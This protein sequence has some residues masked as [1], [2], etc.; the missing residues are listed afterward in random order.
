MF[1]IRQWGGLHESPDGDTKL[2]FGEAAVM[3]NFKITRDGNLQRRPGSAT[4]LGLMQAYT[5]QI[6]S[7]AQTVR[8]DFDV[9]ST[10]TMYPAALAGAD[11]FV[12]LSGT[13]ALVSFDNA[14]QYAGYFWRYD[15][16]HI[17]QL[18][19]CTKNEPA[20][21]Y[22]WSMKRVTAVSSSANQRVAGVWSGSIGGM[23]RLVSA[24]DGKLW[25]LWDAENGVFA[26]TEIGDIT[27]T[28]SVFFFGFSGKLY[29]LNGTQ[30]KVWDGTTYADVGGYRPLVSITVPPSGGGETLEQVNK[31]SGTRRCRFSPDGK[32]GTFQLPEKDL[33]SIDYVKKT[34]DGSE[35]VS[36]TDFSVD[37]VNGKV[38]FLTTATETFSGDGS[39]KTFV[40][41]NYGISS[42]SVTVGGAAKT[43][44]TD[45]T[46]SFATHCVEFNTAPVSGTDN[47]VIAENTCP[48]EG[49][50]TVEVGWTVSDN[51]RETVA[52][53]KYAELFNGTQDSRVFLYGDGSNKIFYSGLDY[54][55]NPRADYF[56][57]DNEIALGESNTP[58]TG[59]IRHYS[60][61]LAFKSNSTYSIQ[62]GTVTTAE[63]TMIAAYY[64]TPINRTIGNEAVGQVQLVLNSPRTLFG[65]DL[66]EWKNNS[67]YSSNLS[68]DER[69]AKRISDRIYATLSSFDNAHCVCWDDNENQEY[70]ICCSGCALVHN[71]A[72]DAWYYY[73]GFPVSCMAGFRGETYF[74]TTDGR[75][76]RL[77]YDY[78]TDDG[79]AIQTYWESGSLDFWQ[80]WKRKY[81]QEI[82]VGIK[83]E[84]NAEVSVTVQ[85]DRKSDYN[86]KIV[87]KNLMTF[88]HMNF[89]RF[90]FYTSRK[91]TMTRL[92]LKAKKFTYY[93]LI[94]SNGAG[95]T[96]AT[97]TSVDVKVRY[98]GEV[99]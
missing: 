45:Y 69:Q 82:F 60:R 72:A 63:N 62:Y 65:D 30:Y 20:G 44:G 58:V 49:T 57:D 3:R 50:D 95:D 23:E 48:Q 32:S 37:L 27:T 75:I 70:Y 81:S 93:K 41:S 52:A 4:V 36:G 11:G 97:I 91:P 54:D 86:V 77:S 31:L 28:G 33:A 88:A 39:K 42:M 16:F 64:C 38:T 78:R 7:T 17:W 15:A 59:L 68:V 53:M 80:D 79:E 98:S 21:E 99:K 10:L 74:C 46:Y 6:S 96:T 94:L 90:S 5:T 56:P 66:Y 19:S 1:K 83:P 40:L 84:C 55:G 35:Y 76:A 34:S 47:V 73:T 12:A 13:T 2:K 51:F 43:E 22:V 85:T 9:C 61:L 67:S 18:V 14:A 71:Y 92:K 24:C 87:A 29:I 26:K 8:T 89:A 25:S